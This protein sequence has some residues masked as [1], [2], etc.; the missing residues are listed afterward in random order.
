MNGE[1]CDPGADSLSERSWKPWLSK[2]SRIYR[3]THALAILPGT[4][5]RRKQEFFDPGEIPLPVSRMIIR[6]GERRVKNSNYPLFV[7]GFHGILDYMIN[8]CSIC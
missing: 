1:L 2:I 7:D 5:E 4:I 6:T 8:A 3:K